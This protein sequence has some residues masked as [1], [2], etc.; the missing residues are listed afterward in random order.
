MNLLARVRAHIDRTPVRL[1]ALDGV[2]RD[3]V[4]VAR[5]L[6]TCPA[7]GDVCAGACTACRD[8]ATARTWH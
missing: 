2:G 5:L 8:A 6:S 7:C 1:D 4:S 3:R